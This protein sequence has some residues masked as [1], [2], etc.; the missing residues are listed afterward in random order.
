MRP[1]RSRFPAIRDVPEGAGTALWWLFAGVSV[2][3]TVWLVV[4]L[5]RASQDH[6]IS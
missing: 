5:T 3:L 2:V 4:G 6:P 1:S